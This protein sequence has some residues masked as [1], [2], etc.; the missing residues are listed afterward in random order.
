[1][2][3]LGLTYVSDEALLEPVMPK[4]NQLVGFSDASFA[5]CSDTAKSTTGYVLTLNRAAVIYGAKRQ[6]TVM[7]CTSASET[8]VLCKT[9]VAISQAR[10][11]LSDFSA[12]QEIPTPTHVDNKTALSISK[13]KCV[14][15]KTQKH[16][17]VQDKYVT[18]C[19]HRGIITP[20][21][22]PHC[23]PA[24]RYLH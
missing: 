3:N 21:L 23:S 11:I 7:L 4:L 2:A 18:E 16:V 19:V 22:R 8:N 12:R 5:D 14:M 20:C 13:G 9:T 1:M 15:Y 24:G 6:S 10:N 17:T